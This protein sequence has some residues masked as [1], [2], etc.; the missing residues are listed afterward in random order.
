LLFAG[1]LT[2][3]LFSAGYAYK[4]ASYIP[5]YAFKGR[6]CSGGGT[7]HLWEIKEIQTGYWW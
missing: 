5:G 1:S 3:T 6:G 4:Y 7:L 2:G